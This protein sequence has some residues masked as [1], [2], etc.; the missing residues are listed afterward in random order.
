MPRIAVIG[1]GAVG[2]IHVANVIAHGEAELSAICDSRPEAV[3][4]ISDKTGARATSGIAE[5]LDTRP[6]AVIISSST[7]SHG[8]VVGECVTAGVPFLCEKP[9]AQDVRSAAEIVASVK[10][11]GL[12]AAM[13]LNRRF[14]PQYAALR[15]AALS[16]EI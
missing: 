3:M 16:G 1:L 4:A 11:R 2:R 8:E 15:D 13:A 9:L 10:A 14:H 7:A 12:V 5:L 6:D